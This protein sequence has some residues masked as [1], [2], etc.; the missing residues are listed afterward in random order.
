M[1]IIHRYW[2]EQVGAVKEGAVKTKPVIVVGTHKDLV[3]PEQ[4]AKVDGELT[5]LLTESWKKDHQIQGHYFAVSL[6]K[7]NS[8]GLSELTEKL[9]DVALHHANIGIDKVRVPRNFSL[10]SKKLDEERR[11]KQYMSLQDYQSI[12]EG[13]G[14]S[15]GFARIEI[16]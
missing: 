10:L 2:I 11:E 4:Q 1:L 12:G 14:I 6:V 7:G 13:I 5:Q 8:Q 3:L 9:L 16:F 15:I